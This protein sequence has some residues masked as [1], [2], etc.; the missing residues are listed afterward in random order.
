MIPI[1]IAFIT[2]ISFNKLLIYSFGSFLKWVGLPL[3]HPFYFRYFHYKPTILGTPHLWK[4][5]FTRININIPGKYLHMWIL[6]IPSDSFLEPTHIRYHIRNILYRRWTP[7]QSLLYIIYTYINMY[8]YIYIYKEI[9]C[10][11]LTS[12]KLY[13]LV[14]EQFDPENTKQHF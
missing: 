9:L 4:P 1:V 5:S 2:A 8:I 13:P 11:W 12:H 10:H 14:N 3:N 6:W 7:S